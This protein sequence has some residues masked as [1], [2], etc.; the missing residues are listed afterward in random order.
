MA[1]K[2]QGGSPYQPKPTRRLSST[3]VVTTFLIIAST[4]SPTH[5]NSC[6]PFGDRLLE[7]NV[8]V[9][10]GTPIGLAMPEAMVCTREEDEAPLVIFI[11]S[12]SDSGPGRVSVRYSASPWL[13]GTESADP[14]WDLPIGNQ[15]IVVAATDQSQTLSFGTCSLFPIEF[16]N[17]HRLE[18][19]EATLD[20]RWSRTCPISNL[21]TTQ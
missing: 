19:I 17:W 8:F 6:V 13:D 5:A 15:L 16:D 20:A 12:D 21:S 18:A 14:T 10:I 1:A 9:L 3:L 7:P 2:A 11:A 4:A